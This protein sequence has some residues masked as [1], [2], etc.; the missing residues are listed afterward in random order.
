MIKNCKTGFHYNVKKKRIK[1]PPIYGLIETIEYYHCLDCGYK[2]QRTI[3]TECV[4]D[5]VLSLGRD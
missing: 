4:E 3:K 1:Q 5:I 2:T